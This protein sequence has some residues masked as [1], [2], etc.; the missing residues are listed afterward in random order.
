MEVTC[1]GM[2]KESFLKERSVLKRFFPAGEK[3]GK[4]PTTLLLLVVIMATI[5]VLSFTLGR[6]RVSLPELF[7]IFTGNIRETDATAQM[8]LHSVRMPRIFAALLIGGTLSM[9]GA[10]YQGLFKNPMVSPDILGASAGAGFGAAIAI[11]L[12][13][14]TLGIQFSS[15]I[16]GLGAVLLTLAFSKFISGGSNATLILVLAGMVIGTLFSAFISMTKYVADP[17]SKL[18]EITFWLMGGLAAASNKDIVYLSILSIL[19]AVPL[20]VIRWKINILAFG[21]EEAMAL[22]INVKRLRI[23]IILC[24]T[25]L[26][27]ACVSVCGIVGWIGLIVPHIARLV[28]GPNYKT[29]LPASALIGATFL[30]IVDNAA[31]C[32]FS[33]EVPL[34]ILTAV[35]GAPFFLYLLTKGKKSW[36]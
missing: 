33:F 24:S 8:V 21:D 25:L 7:R 36:L 34:G 23:V 29:L 1:K 16:F 35:I 32:A 18:P 10:T 17:D 19:G 14:G 4:N 13:L 20:L 28:V 12:S 26:T 5:T 2:R 15:F 6:Y 3:T 27:A 30:L 9:S 11:L 31:R 22:G